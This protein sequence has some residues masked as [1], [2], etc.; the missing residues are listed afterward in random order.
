MQFLDFWSHS[1]FVKI[2]CRNQ[3]YSLQIIQILKR[4]EEW[5]P[6]YIAHINTK[7]HTYF[8]KAVSVSIRLLK[9]QKSETECPT[10]VIFQAEDNGK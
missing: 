8:E 4:S 1:E 2:K 7:Y 9:L 3:K 5:H 10:C 6:L